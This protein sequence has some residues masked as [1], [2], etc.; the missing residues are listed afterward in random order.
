MC[1]PLSILAAIY[2]M[3][4]LTNKNEL[5]GIMQ[6]GE[7]TLGSNHCERVMAETQDKYL[8]RFSVGNVCMHHSRLS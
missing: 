3:M 8:Y 1:T 2:I 4:V 6:R 5:K 7:H